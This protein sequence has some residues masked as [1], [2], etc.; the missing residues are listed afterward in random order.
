MAWQ[1]ML[2]PVDV[3]S[4]YHTDIATVFNLRLSTITFS[5]KSQDMYIEF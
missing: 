4:A 5:L 1:F 2:N 3:A